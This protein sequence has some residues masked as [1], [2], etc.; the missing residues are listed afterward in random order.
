MGVVQVRA[1]LSAWFSF[2]LFLSNTSE[3]EALEAQQ[4]LGGLADLFDTA[5]V[6][7]HTQRTNPVGRGVLARRQ[8]RDDEVEQLA[9]FLDVR[10]GQRQHVVA[11]VVR[12]EPLLG[13]VQQ[14]HTPSIPTQ[15]A[16]GATAVGPTRYSPC[17]AASSCRTAKSSGRLHEAKPQICDTDER[18]K[19][20]FD[21]N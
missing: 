13:G 9:P 14:V 12:V 20:A 21:K 4:F 10:P 7:E 17:T 16:N 18:L 19:T 5:G 8:Q 15:T 11:D 1:P 6:Q 2:D 3:R